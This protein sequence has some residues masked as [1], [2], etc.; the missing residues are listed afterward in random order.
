VQPFSTRDNLERWANFVDHATEDSQ[1]K[2]F[3]IVSG[4]YPRGTRFVVLPMDLRGLN[5]GLPKK[6]IE[7]QHT[8][9]AQLAKDHP[10]QVIPFVHID[11]RSGSSNM[12]GPNAL[13]FIKR[14]HQEGIPVSQQSLDNVKFKGIKLY[15]PLGYTPS[16]EAVD[17][18]FQYA[19]QHKL[20]VTTHCMSRGGVWTDSL[21]ASTL[22]NYTA[23]C[24]Y[25]AILKKYPDMRLCLAHFGGNKE[26]DDYL[27][28]NRN[29][30]LPLEQ[31]DWVSQIVTMMK[32]GEYPN[33][34]ADIS[35]TMFKY[36]DY[37]KPL[38]LLLL[39]PNVGSRTLFGS[40]Y[41]MSE[42]NKL[43]ERNLSMTLRRCL[44][45]DSFWKIAHNNP[46]QFLG[47]P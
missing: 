26:W 36:Q 21:P 12:D 15:P 43:P 20:P 46:K 45:E 44:G 23:P 40:D 8:E 28:R 30:H 27:S 17:K 38:S 16:D 1:H 34:Y 7:A 25:A 29:I 6:D 24:N 2:L 13:E 42:Q 41:Y 33:L 5:K 9:L 39:D 18:I 14:L 19:N 31:M 32:S 11:P 47:L 10:G 35:F 4:H 3:D 37:A 22:V